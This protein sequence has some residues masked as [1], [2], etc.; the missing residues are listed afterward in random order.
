VRPLVH[1]LVF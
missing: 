1:C